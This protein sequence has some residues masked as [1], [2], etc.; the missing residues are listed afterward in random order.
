VRASQAQAPL[1][2]RSEL[3]ALLG[4]FVFSAALTAGP[5]LWSRPL[6]HDTLAIYAYF[7]D[8]LDSLNRFGK[9][10]W[11]SPRIDFG[12]PTYFYA[13]LGIVNAGK[14]SFVAMGCFA[15][16]LGRLGIELPFV[17]PLYVFY[18]GVLIPFLFLL[19]VW[20]VAREL[21][22][23][24]TARLYV[25]IG[26]AFSPGV[27]LNLSDP[28]ILEYTAYCLY[29]V[30]AYLRF[31]ARPSTRNLAILC[32]TGGL[33]SLAVSQYA[34]I[35]AIPWL[36]LIG[37]TT[38]AASRATRR[39]LRSVPIWQWTAA[40]ALLL[41]TASP[42]LIAYA[43]QGDELTHF[44]MD[45]FA[46]SYGRHKPGNPL[47]FLLASV[48]AITFEWDSY[49]QAEDG[50]PSEFGVRGL[51]RGRHGGFNYLGLLAVPLAALG[52]VY[53]RRRVRLALFILFVLATTVL[54]LSAY[55]PWFS[56]LLVPPTPLRSMNHYSDLLYRGGGFLLV[57]FASGL[58][59]EAAERRPRVLE[60]LPI[61]FGVSSVVSLSLWL[62]LGRPAQTLVG[63]AVALMAGFAVVLLW[64][65]RLPGR[66]SSRLLASG[67]LGLTLI[68]V[69]TAAFWH[70]R[71]L[72]LGSPE[73]YDAGL[74][75]V[76]GSE[77]GVLV[78]MMRETRRM[79]EA[80]FPLHRLPSVAGYCKAHA[81][82]GLPGRSDLSRALDGPKAERSLPLPERLRHEESLRGFFDGPGEGGCGFRIQARGDYNSRDLSVVAAQPLLVFI[83]DAYSRHWRATLDG[84]PAAVL[85]AFGGF[86]A[87]AVPAG[88]SEL[89]LRF[90]PPRVGAA[91]AGSYGVL[92]LLALA[93]LGRRRSP[94]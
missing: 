90:S 25:L 38:A 93:V 75:K 63:L 27:I 81:Y 69:S 5:F 24:R 87:V 10:A 53:G 62:H 72:V 13:L 4:I 9:P 51:A 54:I 7:F 28:G 35:T 70:V 94:E 18:F 55:S 1:R 45:G 66:R 64:A 8:N 22:R 6:Y 68:D 60:R 30:A 47:E 76:I 26:G 21:L 40:L 29:C 52:L 20:L 34:L 31:T 80:N 48:P 88:R 37:I 2:G 23:S 12:Y 89:Q 19:G 82:D 67:V 42:S 57:L 16:V 59:L 91:L 73:D 15:W 58:G 74:G 14:P 39:A 17:T 11:W 92:L 78:V 83:G 84:V 77:R 33:V 56:M 44:A 49:E 3:A 79:R 61:L 50:P 85:P 36:P 65:A 32:L 43:Q 41:T 46:Y 71:L 86:K